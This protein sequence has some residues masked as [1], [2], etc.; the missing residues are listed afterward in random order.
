MSTTIPAKDLKPGDTVL[1]E[2]ETCYL[3]ADG[4]SPK[5]L[6]TE[7]WV[8]QDIRTEKTGTG[9]ICLRI[10]LGKLVTTGKNKGRVK[11]DYPRYYRPEREVE[12]E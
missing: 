8:V 7:R 3:T 2:T 6:M 5:F 12:V 4:M 10:S 11:G 1:E 9:E